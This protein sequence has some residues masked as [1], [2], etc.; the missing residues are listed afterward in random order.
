MQR[1]ISTRRKDAA[2]IDRAGLSGTRTRSNGDRSGNSLVLPGKGSSWFELIVSHVCDLRDRTDRQILMLSW[3]GPEI[4]CIASVLLDRQLVRVRDLASIL[5][6]PFEVCSQVL[7]SP[8]PNKEL[9]RSLGDMS[10]GECAKR[11]LRLDCGLRQFAE[12][13]GDRQLQG[14]LDRIGVGCAP[15]LQAIDRIGL[16]EEGLFNLE[17]DC[18][19]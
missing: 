1:R 4:G 10:A 12:D 8:M 9:R 15:A 13:I 18:S 7:S 19:M 3:R 14:L 17:M 11:L 5:D 6:M 2:K 16:S